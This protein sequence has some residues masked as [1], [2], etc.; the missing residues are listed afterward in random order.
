[1][2]AIQLTPDAPYD[3]AIIGRAVGTNLNVKAGGRFITRTPCLETTSK[4]TPGMNLF[5]LSGT[6]RHTVSGSWVA[7]LTARGLGCGLAR[8]LFAAGA[9]RRVVLL[10]RT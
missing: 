10:L 3:H 7:P 5:P 1:V 8:L 9:G 4:L 2:R 6:L